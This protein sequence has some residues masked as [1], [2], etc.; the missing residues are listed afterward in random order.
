MKRPLLP[1]AIILILLGLILW[2]ESRAGFL[3]DLE[4]ALAK[5]TY[6]AMGGETVVAP[7]VVLVLQGGIRGE[8]LST[9]DVGLFTRAAARL[10]VAV[11][12]VAAW[13]IASAQVRLVPP[14]KPANAAENTAPHFLGGT[15]LLPQPPVS[16]Q[17]PA[18][19][20]FASSP[21]AEWQ[22]PGFAGSYSN[23]PA[24]MGWQTG[25]LNLPDRGP[26]SDPA[27]GY[28]L[29]AEL[30]GQPVPSLALAA[31]L[32]SA[33]D[34]PLRISDSGSLLWGNF[35]VPLQPGGILIPGAGLLGK[36]H[37]VDMDDLLLEAER[38]EKNLP[39][40][41]SLRQVLAGSVALLGTL[42]Q[43][44]EILTAPGSARRLSLVEFQGLALQSL[45][46][47]LEPPCAPW[48]AGGLILLCLL[49]LLLG[50]WFIPPDTA[51]FVATLLFCGSLLLGGALAVQTQILFPALLPSVLWPAAA[52]LRHVLR[53]PRISA[54][55]P[56][57]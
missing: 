32:G 40:D 18:R 28:L 20:D 49:P 7:A 30:S 22:L 34:T 43:D 5:W 46:S 42:A 11:A 12:G 10:E 39:G 53:R 56:V 54:A 4:H 24:G 57:K 55:A 19:L 13:E 48:W 25:F 27:G 15:L 23:F 51:S 8:E 17:T 6:A 38:R 44:E 31:A 41:E 50:L 16:G 3:R 2:R 52:L 45:F 36:L 1:A 35:L 26:K 47:A 29:L 37:R 9:L 21:P 33:P 14:A